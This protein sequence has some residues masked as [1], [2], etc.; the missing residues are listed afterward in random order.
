MPQILSFLFQLVSKFR[1]SFEISLNLFQ[2]NVLLTTYPIGLSLSFR[3]FVIHF[4][5]GC[6]GSGFCTS[7][8]LCADLSKHQR[9]SLFC[10]RPRPCRIVQWRPSPRR[11][12]PSARTM[13]KPVMNE[14]SDPASAFRVMTGDDVDRDSFGHPCLPV[15]LRG[16]YEVNVTSDVAGPSV[17]A[18]LL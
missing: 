10:A 4:I 6:H 8:R 16:Q 14:D 2:P 13:A 18:T 1:R 12:S 3:V 7:C 11:A 17:S 15:H 5:S 9:K